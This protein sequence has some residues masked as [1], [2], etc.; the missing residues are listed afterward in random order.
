M[1]LAALTLKPREFAVGVDLFGISNWVRT[2]KSIAAILGGV[3]R[4]FVPGNRPSGKE[5]AT[6]C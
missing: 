6:C 4:G 3:P 5:T 2:L 1:T